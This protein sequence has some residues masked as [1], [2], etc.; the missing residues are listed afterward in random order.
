MFYVC[1]QGEM[2]KLYKDMIYFFLFRKCV[3]K[4]LRKTRGGGD[5]TS[6]SKKDVQESHI[7]LKLITWNV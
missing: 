1:T 5:N 3:L 6:F 7:F 4:D 2:I